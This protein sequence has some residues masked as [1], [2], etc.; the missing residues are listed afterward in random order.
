MQAV[1]TLAVLW[2]GLSAEQA[3]AASTVNAAHAVGRGHLTGTLEAGKR[4]DLLVLNVPDY[5]EIPR[6]FGINHVVMAIREGN[7]VFN[8]TRW[9][10]SGT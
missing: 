3:I 8:R 9:K 5:R 10:V 4:A 2:Q 7:V 1:L 6:R